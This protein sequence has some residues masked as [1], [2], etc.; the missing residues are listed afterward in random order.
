MGAIIK[1]GDGRPLKV[2][3]GQAN[4][5]KANPDFMGV[6]LLKT[7]VYQVGGKNDG[8]EIVDGKILT[9]QS[10]I[11]YPD[12]NMQ[13]RNYQFLVGYNPDLL[14]YG[15]V[16]CPGVVSSFDA[17]KLCLRFDAAKKTDLSEFEY[18]FELY[19]ID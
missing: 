10:V 18:I 7:K 3:G 4:F 13:V 1:L 9:N 14:E 5:V 2:V 17:S 8:E 6:R 11:V 15:A 16:S 12:I 19:L